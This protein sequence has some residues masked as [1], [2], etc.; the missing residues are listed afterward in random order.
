M[1]IGR[2]LLLRISP[3][4]CEGYPADL[5]LESQFHVDGEHWSVGRS[6]LRLDPLNSII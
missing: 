4:L 2:V 3:I 1:L 6:V 5:S